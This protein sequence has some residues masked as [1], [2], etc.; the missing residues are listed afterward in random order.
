M[1]EKYVCRYA[2]RF[3]IFFRKMTFKKHRENP[4]KLCKIYLVNFDYYVGI[5]G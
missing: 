1:P 3:H 4:K 5:D 2:Q